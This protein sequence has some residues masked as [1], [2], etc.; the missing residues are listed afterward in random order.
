MSLLTTLK[1]ERTKLVKQLDAM[2]VLIAA[3]SDGSEPVEKVKAT[4]ATTKTER[5]PRGARKTR[6]SASKV[7]AIVM[8]AVGAGT[9]TV[10]D[11]L[12]GNDTIN[13]AATQKAVKALVE[14]GFLTVGDEK[15]NPALT[16]TEKEFVFEAPTAESN[17]D[18]EDGALSQD[19]AEAAIDPSLESVS[20][21][22]QV[23]E[24]SLSFEG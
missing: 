4:R 15:R 22:G 1:S 21:E 7:Q 8:Q 12:K 24:E 11:I 5:T 6:V 18:V 16:A 9:N 23:V 13:Y 19:E 2:D 17:G 3:Y 10:K 14:G 20:D